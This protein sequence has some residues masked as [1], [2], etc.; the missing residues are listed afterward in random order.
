MIL[1]AEADIAANPWMNALWAGLVGAVIGSVVVWFMRPRTSAPPAPEPVAPAKPTAEPLRLLALL[2][3]EGRLLDFLLEDIQGIPDAQ[4]AAA[5]RDIHGTCGKALREHL[6]LKRII[7]GEED[8]TTTVAPGFDP[9]AIRL[10][11]QVTGQPPFTGTLRHHGWR[12]SEIKLAKPPAGADEFVVQ[13][14]EVELA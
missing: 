3:R 1:L 4:I 7:D 6:T 12:V 8:S 9:S 2:Q 13:P 5:V 10:T 11:G 14:A